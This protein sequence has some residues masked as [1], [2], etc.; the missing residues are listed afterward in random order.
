MKVSRTEEKVSG[1]KVFVALSGGVDSA[2]AAV[3]LQ[4]DGAEVT[5][6]FI[7]NW[8]GE[9][10]GLERECPWKQDQESAQAVCA[11]LGIPFQTY[12]FEREYRARVISYFFNEY[13]AGRTPN[14]DILCNKEIKFGL[15]LNRA[16]KDGAEMIAT[17]HYAG[18]WLHEDGSCDL[19]RAVDTEKDQTYFLYQL[20]QNQLQKSL[21]PLAQIK[22]ADVRALAKKFSLPNSQRKDSQGIC[23]L[24][25]VDVRKFLIKEIHEKK[26]GI[27]DAD[28]GETL[29]EHNGVWFYTLGQREKIGIGG[30]GDPYFVSERDISTNTL[31]V[32]KGKENP[33]LYVKSVTLENIHEIGSSIPIDAHLL[34]QLRYRQVPVR[35]TLRGTQIIL[36]QPAWITSPGQSAVLIKDDIV[37]GGGI[38]ASVEPVSR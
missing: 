31:F 32:A 28:T 33:R 14:P 24:G 4:R 35:C 36:D 23:F 11:H 5:G 22:K 19:I 12:N 25:K 15:F 18:K 6:V 13:R 8:S 27:I 26:G 17:G 20:S 29:G 30:A 21:F 1:K 9:E 16:L 38:I 10:F 34:C 37:L 3:L 7:K 2:V